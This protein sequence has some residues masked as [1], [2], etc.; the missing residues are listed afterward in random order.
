MIVG[1]VLL[2]II[3]AALIAPGWYWARA[4]NPQSL[5]LFLLPA[6]GIGLWVAL[7]ASGIGSQSLSNL[8][9]VLGVV[10]AAVG[11][12]HLKFFVFDRKLANQRFA[13]VGAFVIVAIVAVAFRL[14]TPQLPE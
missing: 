9:E 7:T 13:V 14:F 1:F 6:A 10:V 3:G 4:Q 5:L 8:S 11:A 2:S 12:A